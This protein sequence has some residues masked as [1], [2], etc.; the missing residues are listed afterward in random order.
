MSDSV[1]R[2]RWWQARRDR[3]GL[4]RGQ[5]AN[6]LTEAGKCRVEQTDA[7]EVL[8]EAGMDQPVGAGLGA[9]AQGGQGREVVAASDQLRGQPGE[10][11]AQGASHGAGAAEVDDQSEVAVP[12]A[13]QRFTAQRRKDIASQ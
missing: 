2:I 9:G 12:V 4:V 10:F 5:V 1:V 3:P 6:L 7:H 11:A 8:A 13:A